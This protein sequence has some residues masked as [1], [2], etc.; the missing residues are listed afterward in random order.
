MKTSDLVLIGGAGLLAYL[1][2]SSTSSPAYAQGASARQGGQGYGSYGQGYYGNSSQVPG[3]QG[4]G[5]NANYAPQNYGQNYNY[6]RNPGAYTPLP[7]VTPPQIITSPT[8]ITQ[9][10]STPYT[11]QSPLVT[12]ATPGNPTGMATPVY[13]PRYSAA[14]LPPRRIV[15]FNWGPLRRPLL[16]PLPNIIG[17]GGPSTAPV[18]GAGGAYGYGIGGGQYFNSLGI[19]GGVGVV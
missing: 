9:V 18:Y 4:Y 12:I 1:L 15:N 6:M 2:M 11:P 5:Q 8:P 13:A 14:N 3:Y 10:P 7:P 19:P 16:G 17:S